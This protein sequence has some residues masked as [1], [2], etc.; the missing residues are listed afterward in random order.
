MSPTISPPRRVGGE[1]DSPITQ[2]ASIAATPYF[3]V[4]NTHEKSQDVGQGVFAEPKS[5]TEGRSC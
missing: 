1:I 2:I 4:I 3:N 5:E